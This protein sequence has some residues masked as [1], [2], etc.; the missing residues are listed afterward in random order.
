MERKSPVASLKFV[1][2]IDL[3]RL[4]LI[5]DSQNY[6]QQKSLSYAEKENISSCITNTRYALT[7]SISLSW[8]GNSKCITI[9][10]KNQG[11]CHRS[12]FHLIPHIFK[13]YPQLSGIINIVDF[14]NK[15]ITEFC[16]EESCLLMSAC[17]TYEYHLAGDTDIKKP[18]KY[19][20]PIYI[21]YLMTLFLV[22]W[23]MK[24]FHSTI[25]VLFPQNFIYG[26]DYFNVSVQGL[27]LYFSAALLFC[28]TTVVF[29]PEVNLID[30]HKL[31]PGIS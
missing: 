20:A 19:S 31:A 6:N 21:D 26:K 25:G 18:I 7:N 5:D 13:D 12:I 3:Q 16:P 14:F 17:P 2:E 9:A 27:Y 24:H 1:P 11:S 15:S 29:I 22:S 8:L 28:N 10:V 30:R 4:G 23:M